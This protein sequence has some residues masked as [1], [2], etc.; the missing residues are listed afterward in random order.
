MATQSKTKVQAPANAIPAAWGDE[1]AVM[2]DGQD[3]IEKD[4]LVGKPFLITAIRNHLGAGEVL[5]AQFE[6]TFSHDVEN[7]E[8]F[9][10]QDSG[11]GIR[12]QV[13][14]YY[15]AIGLD[16]GN[17]DLLDEW[18]D[19]RIVCPKGLRVSEHK[20]EDERGRKV[21]VRSYYLTTSGRRQR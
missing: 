4:A 19:C 9:Q 3:L 8:R 16:T 20:Q 13:D 6:A 5:Y 7:G 1:Q 11:K 12:G 21:D 17:P 18:Q 14:A 15:D 2:L 10:F